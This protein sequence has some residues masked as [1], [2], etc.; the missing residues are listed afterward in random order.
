MLV[1]NSS[2]L[3]VFNEGSF[4]PLR[5][6]F[7]VST[8]KIRLCATTFAADARVK[9]VADFPVN[10]ALLRNL[11][12]FCF[13]NRLLI[14]ERIFGRFKTPRGDQPGVVSI[15]ASFAEAFPLRRR[16][17]DRFRRPILKLSVERTLVS[18]GYKIATA[19]KIRKKNGNFLEKNE[20]FSLREDKKTIWR[21]R[22]SW[23]E[24]D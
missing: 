22:R 24:L 14:L 8:P 1:L 15:F 10:V 13:K 20:N 23:G 7:Q 18:F 11:R 19:A 17:L 16:R 2:F 12:R 6:V 9:N 3:N 21:K 4:E 5:R